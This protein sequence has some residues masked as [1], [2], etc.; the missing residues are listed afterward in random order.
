M[1][2]FVPPPERVTLPPPSSTSFAVLLRILRVWLRVIVTG[3]APQLNVTTPPAATADTTA[4][5]V[6]LAA[7]PLPTTWSGLLTS[8]RPMPD[9]TATVPEVLPGLNVLAF[10]VVNVVSAETPVLPAASLER[11]WTWYVVPA[12]SPVKVWVWLVVSDV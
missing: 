4:A 11:T 12:F 3:F 10:G 1:I 9:G 2:R 6:Q 5:E 7:V 8:S